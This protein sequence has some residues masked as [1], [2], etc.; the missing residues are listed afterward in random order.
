M[1]DERIPI[2]TL[3]KQQVARSRRLVNCGRFVANAEVMNSPD[4]FRVADSCKNNCG[5]F[6]ALRLLRMTN[7]GMW[8]RKAGCGQVVA[9]SDHRR[10]VSYDLISTLLRRRVK[11]GAKAR[12]A[13]RVWLKT[14]DLGYG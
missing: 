1:P 13:A 2:N 8:W 10:F 5:S 3:W 14:S 11:S 4:A 12:N 9:D 7:F 6:D